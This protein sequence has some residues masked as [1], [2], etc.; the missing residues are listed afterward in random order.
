MAP[1]IETNVSLSK[2][3]N[4]TEHAPNSSPAAAAPA[5][6]S[7]AS[8]PTLGAPPLAPGPV[9]GKG[10]AGKA[11][12]DMGMSIRIHTPVDAAPPQLPMIYDSPALGLL[13]VSRCKHER[14]LY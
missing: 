14:I 11:R 2:T 7:Q 13:N 9:L 10:P 3:L 5:R 1:S 12:V 4:E 6:V 8:L